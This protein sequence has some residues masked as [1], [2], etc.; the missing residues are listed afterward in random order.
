MQPPTGRTS[1]TK[2]EQEYILKYLK[3]LTQPKKITFL[4]SH[5][6]KILGITMLGLL[7]WLLLYTEKNVPNFES[8]G[9]AFTVILSVFLVIAAFALASDGIGLSMQIGLVAFLAIL[10][11][12]Y[13]LQLLNGDILTLVIVPFTL[14]GCGFIYVYLKGLIEQK[15]H[16][17]SRKS[18]EEPRYGNS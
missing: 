4:K 17:S 11:A 3:S 2:K 16:R 15:R 7:Q 6:N 9:I 18:W 1:L 13:R 10:N 8:T 14:M 12:E 5:Q